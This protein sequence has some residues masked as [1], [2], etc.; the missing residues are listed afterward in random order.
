MMNANDNENYL[1]WLSVFLLPTEPPTNLNMNEKYFTNM[2]YSFSI[3]AKYHIQIY[4]S[5]LKC[6]K[7][8]KLI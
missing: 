5:F 2:F 1:Y 3:L 4:D 8:Y 6:K 7:W